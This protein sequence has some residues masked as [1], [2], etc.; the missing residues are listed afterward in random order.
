MF[1]CITSRKHTQY[2]VSGSDTFHE[3]QINPASQFSL[4]PIILQL[5][6]I[7][8]GAFGLLVKSTVESM[9]VKTEFPKYNMMHFRTCLHETVTVD[10]WILLP[11]EN[12]L[13]YVNLSIQTHYDET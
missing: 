9:V 3:K 12:M 7:I 11:I 8:P 10:I 5:A 6:K 2:I 13:S 1:E 4:N